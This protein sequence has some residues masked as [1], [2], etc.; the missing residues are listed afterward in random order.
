MRRIKRK[1]HENLTDESISKVIELLEASKPITKKEACEILNI[2]YNTTRLNKIIEDFAD[3]QQYA[4]QRRKNNRGK[5]FSNQEIAEVAINYLQGDS[6]A[7]IAKGLY[8]PTSSV[9]AV[10]ERVGIPTRPSNKEERGSVSVLPDRCISDTFEEGEIVWSAKYN[11]AAVVKAEL[12]I[13]YQ[14]EKPGFG[15]TNYES[16]YSSKCYAIW[17]LES[18]D[19]D[20]EFWIGG[21]ETGGFNAYALAYDLGKIEHL[22]E[23]GVDL[24]RI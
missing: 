16:K 13:D 24:S 5:P 7:A 6:I 2:S 20:K 18:I 4:E 15:D 1:D 12:S 9:K 10:I 3:K 23:Y 22:E 8:R 11:S 19:Q 21:I 17:V 14:A